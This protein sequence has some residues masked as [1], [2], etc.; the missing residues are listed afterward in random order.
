MNDIIL[1]GVNINQLA[2]DKTKT[3]QEAVKYVAEGIAQVRSLVDTMLKSK[4]VVEIETLAKESLEML[5]NCDLVADT[6]GVF[7]TLP[8]G[9][10]YKDTIYSGELI[11]RRHG[12]FTDMDLTDTEEENLKAVFNSTTMRNLEKLFDSMEDTVCLWEGESF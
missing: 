11:R 6:T 10:S 12:Y 2:A 7:Y 4:D 5:T 9:G 3:Q 8:W 1:N